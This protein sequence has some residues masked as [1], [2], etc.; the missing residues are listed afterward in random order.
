MNKLILSLIAIFLLSGCGSDNEILTNKDL[1]L[2]NFD[3]EL[4]NADAE[5]TT[6]KSVADKEP[7]FYNLL[8]YNETGE[9]YYQ[10]YHNAETGFSSNDINKENIFHFDGK[11]IS[12]QLLLPAGKYKVAFLIHLKDA[13][14]PNTY[15]APIWGNNFETDSFGSDFSLENPDKLHNGGVYFNTIEFVVLPSHTK[16]IGNIKLQP[17][18][19]YIDINIKNAQTFRYPL[20]TN[21]LLFDISPRYYGFNV[22][23]KK[24]IYKVDNPIVVELASVRSNPTFNVRTIVSQTTDENNNIIAKISYIKIDKDTTIL[25]TIDLDMTKTNIDNGYYYD[26]NGDIGRKNSGNGINISLGSMNSQDVIINL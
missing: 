5:S 8:V 6:N 17:M 13:N 3:V 22:K 4:P 11:K 19:S 20:G 21:A 12:T 26:I 1:Y 16:Q 18:W 25:E 23:T 24:A 7:S 14:N 9:V 10:S 15:L 2:V